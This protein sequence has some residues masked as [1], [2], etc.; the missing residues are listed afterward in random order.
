LSRR[1]RVAQ[2]VGNLETGGMQEMVMALM[3]GLDR[4]RFEPV[5]V[6]FKAINHYH[7]EIEEKGWECH[8]L[9]V[10]RSFRT[11]QLQRL[12][13]FFRSQ[14]ID[15]IH[16]HADFACFAA[17]AAVQLISHRPVIAHYQNTYHHRLDPLF[18]RREQMLA[19]LTDLIVACSKGVQEFMPTAFD[20]SGTPVRVIP[21][22]IDPAAFTASSKRRAEIRRELGIPEDCFHVLHT[23]RLEPHKAPERLLKA[24]EIAAP[25]LGKWRA[26]F[27]GGGQLLDSL[28]IKTLDLGFGENVRFAGWSREIHRHLASADAFVLCSNNEGLPLSLV[29]AMA[30]GTP[31]VASNIIGPQE[32][33]THGEDGMLVDSRHPEQIARA[34]VRLRR[35]PELWRQF[36]ERGLVRATEFTHQRF[37][38][39]ISAAYEELLARPR[40]EHPERTLLRKWWFLW[41]FRAG[42]AKERR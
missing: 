38:E 32:V 15:I 30:T 27:V 2:I 8:K 31:V 33:V 29:E 14:R 42:K 39:E 1:I 40:P 7:A 21:N 6:H 26:T 24:L 5:L 25:E 23:A 34:L 10:S 22:G 13:Q 17:R 20:L 3:R 28:Q 37:V 9:R 36:Q 35:E 11:R 41:E 19:P 18:R 16:A 4:R 12:A